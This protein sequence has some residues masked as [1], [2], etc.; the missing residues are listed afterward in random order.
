MVRLGL[1]VGLHAGLN[2]IYDI[3]EGRPIWKTIPIRIGVTVFA[4]VVMVVSAVIVVVSGP[5]AEQV[6]DLI[7]AGDTAV[8]VWGILKW[9]VLLV[10]V[11]VLFAVLFWASPNAKQGGVKWVSPGGV[12]AVVIWLIVSGLFAV[13][14]AYFSSYNKTYGS[15]AG[16][17]VFLVWLWLTNIAILLGAEVNAES[18]AAGRSPRA[19]P[20]T[21][22]PSPSRATRAPWTTSTSEP[23]PRRPSAGRTDRP[24]P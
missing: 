20:R 2:V 6:G 21:S 4:V 12:I 15:L 14:V 13:Y 7:G 19:C 17:V 18:T 5:V 22:S 11:S 9:P 24:R 8:L 3:P 23:P 16:V 1:R 10:L